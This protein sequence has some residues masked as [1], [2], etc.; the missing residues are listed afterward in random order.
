MPSAQP[1]HTLE[2]PARPAVR[3]RSLD[4]DNVFCSAPLDIVARHLWRLDE[5]LLARSNTV[6][7]HIGRD[8]LVPEFR[9]VYAFPF[10]TNATLLWIWPSMTELI[11][12]LSNAIH[13]PL[14]YLSVTGH[15]HL[16]EFLVFDDGAVVQELLDPEIPLRTGQWGLA[17]NL[18]GHGPRRFKSLDDFLAEIKSW[19]TPVDWVWQFG[20]WHFEEWR[21]DTLLQPNC[22]IRWSIR[23][24][25][26]ERI[27]ESV[28]EVTAT[29][30][31]NVERIRRSIDAK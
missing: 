22:P 27:I 11:A 3:D 9:D 18:G 6:F 30:A 1:I 20:K 10:G 4:F 25:A 8:S 5:S 24:N 21:R 13:E 31:A 7:Y 26:S 29:A 19:Y 14:A 16:R 2:T 17:S 12:D 28:G 15:M 23:I